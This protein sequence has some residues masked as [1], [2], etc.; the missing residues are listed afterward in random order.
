MFP[1]LQSK[2]VPRS[3]IPCLVPD[4][5]LINY[6]IKP[7]HCG[8]L[9]NINLSKETVSHVDN[10]IR[11]GASPASPQPVAEECSWRWAVGI[12]RQFQIHP[13][14]VCNRGQEAFLLK[15]WISPQDPN[16]LMWNLRRILGSLFLTLFL[17]ISISPLYYYPIIIIIIII[18][19]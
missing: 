14:S 7:S 12:R 3:P 5:L 16:G 10:H 17:N 11:L 2:L 8:A 15:R 9:N 1:S 4:N 18:I 13:E 6:P 19:V